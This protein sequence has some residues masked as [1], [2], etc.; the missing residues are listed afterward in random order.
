[1][2][3][4]HVFNRALWRMEGI[5]MADKNGESCAYPTGHEGYE[6]DPG[7]TKRE[8]FAAMAMQGMLSNDVTSGL[9]EITIAQLAVKQADELIFELNRKV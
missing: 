3:Y 1:M 8:L 6:G 7:L 5:V 2:R 9:T 4:R